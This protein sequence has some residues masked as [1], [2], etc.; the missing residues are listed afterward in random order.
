MICLPEK[1]TT[2][3]IPGLVFKAAQKAQGHDEVCYA[4]SPEVRN[5][6]GSLQKEAQRMLIA[7]FGVY[8]GEFTYIDPVT[9]TTEVGS[10]FRG[11]WFDL[12]VQAEQKGWE[13]FEKEIVARHMIRM[14]NSGKAK[15]TLYSAPKLTAP[16]PTYDDMHFSKIVEFASALGLVGEALA[17]EEQNNN[18]KSVVSG[19][20]EALATP[21]EDEVLVDD[22]ELTAA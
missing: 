19:L 12:D 17:Y 14:A 22:A 21:V 2:Y 16:W 11:G 4:G 5:P 20:R 7:E 15:F 3:Y 8:G 9:E 18:R 6:D 13:S 1:A 10:E